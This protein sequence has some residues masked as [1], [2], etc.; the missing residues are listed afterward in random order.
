M[1]IS[2]LVIEEESSTHHKHKKHKGEK[3]R[4]HSHD[5]S[6][7]AADEQLAEVHSKS[8]KKH[9][10][11][12]KE[13]KDEK[14]KHRKHSHDISATALVE[15]A[16][17]RTDTKSQTKK[18][19]KKEKKQKKKE[20]KARRKSKDLTA[21]HTSEQPL[22]MD[23]KYEKQKE[24]KAKTNDYVQANAYTAVA[25]PVVEAA[26]RKHKAEKKRKSSLI[27][28]ASAVPTEQDA[29]SVQSETEVTEVIEIASSDA[30]PIQTDNEVPDDTDNI[31]SALF[32]GSRS[33]SEAEAIIPSASG[34]SDDAEEAIVSSDAETES[35]P[36]A[37]ATTTTPATE[38]PNYQE[39]LDSSSASAMEEE[40]E[41][42]EATS[43]PTMEES[44][45]SEAL[46]SDSASAMV[47]EENEGEATAP[48]TMEE[49]EVEATT[50]PTME[51]TSFP[52]ILD[53]GS[54]FN[55][56]EVESNEVEEGEKVEQAEEVEEAEV[57]EEAE[58]AE[59][60][61][62]AEDIYVTIS[63]NLPPAEVNDLHV[64]SMEAT[65]EPNDRESGI[66]DSLV[67]DSRELSFEPQTSST[68]IMIDSP[69]I[70]ADNEM[71]VDTHLEQS[72]EPSAAEEEAIV[73]ETSLAKKGIQ[74]APSRVELEEVVNSAVTLPPLGISIPFD[75]PDVQASKKVQENLES[76]SSEDSDDDDDDAFGFGIFSKSETDDLDQ[77][78]EGYLQTGVKILE[79]ISNGSAKPVNVEAV[80][81]ATELRKVCEAESKSRL[82]RAIKEGGET[83][84][85]GKEMQQLKA[86]QLGDED[87]N[88]HLT[89][90]LLPG[91]MS[92]SR[93]PTLSEIYAN[94]QRYIYKSIHGR[95]PPPSPSRR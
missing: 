30:T 42:V 67:E 71:E 33:A 52:N 31:I 62:E 3:H 89:S 27:P 94:S 21:T 51:E 39:A 75:Q 48:P 80:E 14:K 38:E 56:E 82:T 58:E 79:K 47:E 55:L 88:D 24:L 20:E 32:P 76:S 28:I 84:K 54:D 22:P 11:K 46:G 45:F 41:E 43:T 59:S 83:V 34:V 8:K 78:D 2:A 63:E 12:N 10:K 95:S 86:A 53:S 23:V 26:P 18:E 44:K 69:D 40:E 85:A 37:E 64:T 92:K 49:K 50:T 65:S 36:E 68:P 6:A 5:L 66:P 70:H 90:G 81:A 74:A 91:F 9:K 72:F 4:K 60:A 77:P 7:S 61:K 19:K 17:S 87:D 1:L 13:K 25:P 29:R 15:D 73:D 57:V 35:S 16:G 93:A